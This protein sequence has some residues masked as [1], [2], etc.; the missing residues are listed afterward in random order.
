LGFLGTGGFI[1][2]NTAKF[3]GLVL[4]AHLWL[5]CGDAEEGSTAT[6]TD[7]KEE[8]LESYVAALCK[9][10]LSC[11]DQGLVAALD[12]SSC[13]SLFNVSAKSQR[14]WYDAKVHYDAAA[15]RQCVD[16]VNGARCEADSQLV[17]AVLSPCERVLTGDGA[18]GASCTDDGECQAGLSCATGAMCPSTCAAPGKLAESCA[19]RPCERTLV[20]HED[21]CVLP[22]PLGAACGVSA[23]RCAA[24]SICDV[25]PGGTNTCRPV[26]EVQR[27]LTAGTVC[28]SNL[29][30]KTGLFCDASATPRV[31]AA[32]RGAGGSCMAYDNACAVGFHCSSTSS[33]V[34]G[35]CVADASLGQACTAALDCAQ[36]GCY[37]GTC[38]FQ[39]ALAEACSEH[40]TC[41]SDYCDGGRCALAP[42]CFEP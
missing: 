9:Y 30:C 27:V 28:A 26:A 36:G 18:A 23:P 10:I 3:V 7:T 15:G 25:A 35:T 29:Q 17:L 37:E 8:F 5:G 6:K 13:V 24:A 41:A 19:E 11:P 38:R 22:T 1:M 39:A 34:A 33:T 12:L 4:G 16:A 21:V 2:G 32:R 14:I 42:A 31:C 40:R 20:C